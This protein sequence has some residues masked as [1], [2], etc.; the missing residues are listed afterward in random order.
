MTLKFWSLQLIKERELNKQ[1]QLEALVESQI[2]DVDGNQIPFDEPA[3]LPKFI[4]PKKVPLSAGVYNLVR[5]MLNECM[6]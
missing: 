5:G 4:K 6:P 2:Y 3:P 1:V